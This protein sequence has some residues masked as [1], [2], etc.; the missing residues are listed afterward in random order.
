L[1]TT[2][3]EPDIIINYQKQSNTCYVVNMSLNG[4]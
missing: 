4:G 1:F 3:S 2:I